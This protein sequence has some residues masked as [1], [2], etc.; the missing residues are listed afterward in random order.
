MQ[1]NY[2]IKKKNDIV[3]LNTCEIQ[4]RMT[5]YSDERWYVMLCTIWYHLY[6]FD[7]VKNIHGGVLHLSK[8]AGYLQLY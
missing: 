2:Q 4:N 5:N 7:D 3:A 8:V 1:L 6:N